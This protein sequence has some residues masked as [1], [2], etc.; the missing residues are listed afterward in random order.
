MVSKANLKA[1]KPKLPSGVSVKHV[2][3]GMYRL[4]G[5]KSSVTKAK[6]LLSA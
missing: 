6:N 3:G 2:N 1:R 5:A 4:T